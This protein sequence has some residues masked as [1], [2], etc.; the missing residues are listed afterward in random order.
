MTVALAVADAGVHTVAV[1]HQGFANS[2]ADVTVLVRACGVVSEQSFALQGDGSL[3]YLL[4]G[5]F[6]VPGPGCSRGDAGSA[7]ARSAWQSTALPGALPAETA[8]PLSDGNYSTCIETGGLGGQVEDLSPWWKVDLGK[9]S[10]VEAVWVLTSQAQGGSSGHA[11]EV[12]IY[13]ANITHGEPVLCAAGVRV[14]R[15]E[16]GG[17]DAGWPPAA[18]GCG[19][20]NGTRGLLGRYVWVMSTTGSPLSL[21]EVEVY[22]APLP[23][24]AQAVLR[25][26]TGS[27]GYGAVC[28]AF[29][30]EVE[31]SD[32]NVTWYPMWNDTT[33]EATS[34]EQ[35]VPGQHN[36]DE[37]IG[38]GSALAASMDFAEATIDD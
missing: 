10:R 35:Q 26:G 13:V 3:G 6:T 22:T 28:G 1:R 19:A 15:S 32:D 2:T 18:A 16:G 37:G 34:T 25:W 24:L 21:C 29:A 9:V 17:V 23:I 30:V 20:H 7:G 8:A 14:G 31:W 5:L 33:M 12:D 36:V 38:S 27:D 4:V 11:T